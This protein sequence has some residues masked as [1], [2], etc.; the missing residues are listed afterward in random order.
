MTQHKIK[1]R[2]RWRKF[3]SIC[4][5]LAGVT[6]VLAGLRLGEA[7]E[8]ADYI[9]DG[10]APVFA[11][12]LSVGLPA[13]LQ[14]GQLNG[15]GFSYESG[16]ESLRWLGS[17]TT[18][19]AAE[20]NTSWTVQHTEIRLRAG[21]GARK[22]LGRGLIMLR[23]LA[24]ATVLNEFRERHQSNRLG[25][26]VGPLTVSAWNTFAA[27]DVEAGVGLEIAEGWG[28][29]LLGG[30]TVHFGA[31]GNDSV[32]WAGKLVVRREWDPAK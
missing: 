9:A 32:G 26:D 8:R 29:G 10:N 4:G 30:P 14:T 17:A 22:R 24:G 18:G 25:S 21:A 5:P 12:G 2:L 13:A 15:F 1:Q 20:S 7:A 6:L 19:W 31:T 16:G 28:I 3:A 11:A 27:V 23:V